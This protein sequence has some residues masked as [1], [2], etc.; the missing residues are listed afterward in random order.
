[1]GLLYDFKILQNPKISENISILVVEN[2]YIHTLDFYRYIYIIVTCNKQNRALYM[3][4]LFIIDKNVKSLISINRRMDK[5]FM[6]NVYYAMKYSP[7]ST[8]KKWSKNTCYKMN[9]PWKCYAKFKSLSQEPYILWFHVYEISRWWK[10][11]MGSSRLVVRRRARNRNG[12]W[13]LMN[14]DFSDGIWEWW[15]SHKSVNKLK[16]S[17]LYTL[18]G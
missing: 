6:C 8:I 10:F 3:S 7:F 15:W 12:G 18:K 17:E 13:L 16:T 5:R 1:M 4:L 2:I 9:G 14:M 11:I